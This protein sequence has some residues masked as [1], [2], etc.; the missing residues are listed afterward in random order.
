MSVV[1]RVVLHACEACDDPC[2]ARS[3]RP[4]S[5]SDRAIRHQRGATAMLTRRVL[6]TSV[7]FALLSA[8]AFAQ[9]PQPP[10]PAKPAPAVTAPAKPAP[11]GAAPAPPPP[12]T[13]LNTPTAPEL[14]Q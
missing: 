14:Q 10:Q 12:T 13:N 7:T 11:T 5:Y 9:G 6:V 8:P 1:N 4:Q 2:N 3:A